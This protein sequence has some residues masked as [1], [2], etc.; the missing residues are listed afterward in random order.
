[1][2]D[3]SS[4]AMHRLG[5]AGYVCALAGL[6][7]VAFGCAG[8]GVPPLAAGTEVAPGAACSADA[9]TPQVVETSP[10][11]LPAEVFER[12]QGW[13]FRIAFRVDE[14]GGPNSI[15]VTL[16]HERD[17]A[18]AIVSALGTAF[19]GYRFCAP[20]AYSPATRWTAV[21]RFRPVF[22]SHESGDTRMFV[23]MFIP[24]Y[25]RDDLHAGRV[26][27]NRVKATFTDEG[28]PS[29]LLLVT[30]SGD[31]VLDM[32]SLQAMASWQ[33]V[34][35]PGVEPKRPITFEQPYSYAIH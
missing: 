35:R 21:L 27:A 12:A 1:M 16:T 10:A 24:A 30:S 14:R 25:T 11:A 9:V 22:A 3:G 20:A 28:R 34:F 6:T 29:R 5:R 32:K 19:A 18:D 8:P 7:T 13:E 31:A 15:D 4:P 26:G 33:L 23:Q 17:D 2:I